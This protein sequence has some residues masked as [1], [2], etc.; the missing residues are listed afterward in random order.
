MGFE[1][2]ATYGSGAFETPLGLVAIDEDAAASLTR[3]TPVVREHEAAH[4]REHS[5]E[6]QLP[7]LQR[8]APQTP[9]L[10]LVMGFQTRATATALADGLVAA[11]RGRRA[12][13]IASSDLS[14]YHDA[15]AAARLDGEVI[16]LVAR[17]DA[18]GLQKVLDIR[19]EHACGGG[20]IVA[21]MRAAQ[22]LGARDAIALQYSDSGDVS[23]DKSSV[24][25]YMAA[26]L[27]SFA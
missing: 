23:G 15:G 14:H 1:G 20:P 25:G 27:G 26:A 11:L 8:L 24:V 16:D 4:T 3:A 22:G 13:L 2:V 19:P 5:L 7:F 6:M 21:V 18:E 9:I 17:F 12:L 10:P